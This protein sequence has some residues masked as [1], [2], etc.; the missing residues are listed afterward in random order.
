MCCRFSLPPPPS[1][2]Y[3]MFLGMC[4]RSF[5]FFS[6]FLNVLLLGMWH[7]SHVRRFGF[8]SCF[9]FFSRCFCTVFSGTVIRNAR[10]QS[11]RGSCTPVRKSFF[12]LF[13]FFNA[14]L[15]VDPRCRCVILFSLFLTRFPLM[16]HALVRMCIFFLVLFFLRSCIFCVCMCLC[17]CLCPLPV[18]LLSCVD[19]HM[20]LC[21]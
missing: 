3:V 4:N 18:S 20:C 7:R 2:L 10:S 15:F 1:F 9:F 13:P 6:F 14:S 12:F 21:E 11:L 5:L 17:M 8:F 16:G 19:V